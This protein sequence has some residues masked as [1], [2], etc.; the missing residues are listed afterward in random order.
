MR[1]RGKFSRRFSI[2]AGTR[3]SSL[4]RYCSKKKDYRCDHLFQ[5]Y[6]LLLLLFLVHVLR[7][8]ETTA[9]QVQLMNTGS[10]AE[11]KGDKEV[12]VM[13]AVLGFEP[14]SSSGPE[15]PL[16]DIRQYPSC[17]DEISKA[18]R[19]AWRKSSKYERRITRSV[20]MRTLRSDR[21]KVHSA[22]MC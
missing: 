10:N 6:K 9:G 18:I 16:S 4:T 15:D 1:G 14:S 2:L 11:L 3:P 22:W 20:V 13:T 12:C 17:V 19:G 8:T 5:P 21:H 7:T